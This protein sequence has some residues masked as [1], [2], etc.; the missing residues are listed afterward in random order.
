M[1]AIGHTRGKLRA[2][3]DRHDIQ[4]IATDGYHLTGIPRD[5]E[6]GRPG[7]DEANGKRFVSCWNG[8]INIP[9]PEHLPALIKVLAG[10]GDITLHNA[11]EKC[12]LNWKG[13]PIKN[14]EYILKVVR[15]SRNVGDLWEF[16]TL[17]ELDHWLD[18][19]SLGLALK[20]SMDVIHRVG[21]KYKKVGER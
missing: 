18:K 17:S 1:E 14:G 20:G 19:L 4:I 3:I 13:K 6:Y 7:E 11:M 9:K 5:P 2:K 10:I 15:G 8:C 16:D 21:R 12:G